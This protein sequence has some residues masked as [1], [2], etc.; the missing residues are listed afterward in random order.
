MLKHILVPLDGSEPAEAAIPVAAGLS[1]P[2]SAEMTLVH[3]IE[4]GAPQQV[5]GYTHL[6][7]PDQARAYLETIAARLT[8]TGIRVRTHVHEGVVGDVARGLAAHGRELTADLVVMACHGRRGPRD[9]F[10]G[11]M[12]EQILATGLV[13]VLMVRADHKPADEASFR[14]LLVPLEGRGLHSAGLEWAQ[15]LAVA[16]GVRLHLLVVI[17]TRQTLSAEGAASGQYLPGATEAMLE[18]ADEDARRYLQDHLRRL[19]GQSISVSAEVA[20]GDPAEGIARVA[21]TIRPDLIILSSHG[22]AGLQA[23]WAGSVA[24]RVCARTDNPLLLIP[25]SSGDRA[26]GHPS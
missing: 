1:R 14:N 16:L 18:L 25:E 22:K 26:K 5:H 12:G 13:P 20:R 17:P 9:W 10:W 7:N 19:Q 4:R 6:Q 11:N 8:A 2:L 21:K 15:R 3:V 24:A 23:F